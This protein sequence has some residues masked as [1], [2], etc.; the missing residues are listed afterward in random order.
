MTQLKVYLNIHRNITVSSFKM[1]L[2]Q[3]QQHHFQLISSRMKKKKQN[4]IKAKFVF[5]IF[6]KK[7]MKPTTHLNQISNTFSIQTFNNIAN[8]NSVLLSHRFTRNLLYYP[9]TRMRGDPCSVKTYEYNNK[10][11]N[12]LYLLDN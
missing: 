4:V 1:L 12:N 6:Y 2:R 5:I 9:I 10:K 8:S 11:L 7:S 3:M